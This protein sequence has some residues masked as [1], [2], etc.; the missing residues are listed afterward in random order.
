M[1][2]TITHSY[3]TVDVYDVLPDDIKS[4]LS[5]SK[6]KMFGQGFDPLMF[7]N[8]FSIIPGKNI[9]KMHSYCHDNKTQTFFINMLKAIKEKKLI[10]D[11]ECLSFL[12]GFICHYVLDSNL[13]PYI[14]YK[15]GVMK[16]NVPSTYKYN[17]LHEIMEVF[18]DNDMVKRREKINPYKFKL[19]KFCFDK[20][21][22][23]IN[24]DY[25]IDTT[26][27]KTF[28]LKGMSYI[29]YKSLKQMKN[30]LYIFRRDRYGIKRFIYKIV[31]TFT[32]KR[33]FRFDA[34]SYH[35][36]LEDKHNYLNINNSL[37]R[38]PTTYDI[39]ST[40]SFVDL[41]MKSIREARTIYCASIDYLSGKAIDLEKI[42][43]N[44]S[45]ITGL[46]C[47]INKELKYFEF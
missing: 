7:Y 13:H 12:F 41:Y 5:V 20:E 34:V 47:D 26:F 25:I 29:Y 3:F 45:Y 17:N 8:L 18:L 42:F 36:P 21:Q 2:A 44:K 35:Q 4:K 14:I 32:P 6:I 9:R 37:W 1:P 23:S 16:K 33:C 30:Y 38:N 27:Y 11:T 43:T 15:T 39:T 28:K 22:F 46:D 24:L 40:E 31:D 10:Y 19:N